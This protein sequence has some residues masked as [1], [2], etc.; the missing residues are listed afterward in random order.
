MGTSVNTANQTSDI[1]QYAMNN[2]FIMYCSC[3]NTIATFSYA[4]NTCITWEDVITL[5][6]GDIGKDRLFGHIL[7]TLMHFLC[8]NRCSVH[9]KIEILSL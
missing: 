7:F 2:T 3:V 9:N 1:L 5:N 6:T 8:G 4:V